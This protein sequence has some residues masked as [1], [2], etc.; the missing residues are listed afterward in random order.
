[1][2]TVRSLET[3]RGRRLISTVFL[4]YDGS[5]E[6]DYDGWVNEL[7]ALHCIITKTAATSSIA[8]HLPLSL[9]LYAFSPGSFP[10]FFYETPPTL[11]IN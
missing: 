9:S 3:N 7:I 11:K 8:L 10:F 4:K 2:V 6:T 5:D 1:M